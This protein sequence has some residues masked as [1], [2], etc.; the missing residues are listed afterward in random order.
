MNWRQYTFRLA[1]AEHET[2][3]AALLA[4]G[5]CAVCLQAA[6]DEPVFEQQPLHRPVWQHV[7][8]S[9][10]TAYELQAEHF[11]NTVETRLGRSL[12][13]ETIELIADKD[14]S[15]VWMDNFKPIN[16]GKRLWIVPNWL[17]PPIA[18]AINLR[19]DPGLAFGSGSHPT[20]QLCLNWLDSHIRGGET[21][22]D[23]G[24]GSGILAI[25]A[26]LLGADKATATDIDPQ[27][28][29]ATTDN[30]RRNQ[31]ANRLHACL[32]TQAVLPARPNVVIANILAAPLMQL[33][34]TL[35]PLLTPT[36]PLVLAGILADQ[37]DAVISTYKP[38][39]KLAVA[40]ERDGWVLLH[41]QAR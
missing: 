8:L 28:I 29:T 39:R 27:A 20:T 11:L 1:E 23:Y 35:G 37:A 21:V 4:A 30:A 7:K 12:K 24:C 26:L 2:V 31:V 18:D 15:R 10:L 36:C 34:G 22:L 5:A 14:W 16:C 40:A 33:A 6:T 17:E 3:E 9:A 38:Y 41:G 13:P 25:A 32:C 19:L